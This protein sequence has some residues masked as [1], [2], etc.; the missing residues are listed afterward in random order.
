MKT[1][2]KKAITLKNKADRL[3]QLLTEIKQFQKV[4]SLSIFELGK[5]WKEIHD[6]KLWK[7]GTEA[8]SFREFCHKEAK[9]S[10]ATAY[11]CIRIYDVFSPY[12]GEGNVPPEN[13][14]V[15]ALPYITEKKTAEIWYHEALALTHSDYEDS[16]KEAKGGIM[17]VDCPHENMER[18]DRCIVCGKF[19][20]I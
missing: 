13:R 19:F 1:Q 2:N 6:D 4:A 15:K 18:Y 20:K 3:H 17:Q 12:I 9:V 11:N 8:K 7:V 16:L 14:L 5:R 10:H